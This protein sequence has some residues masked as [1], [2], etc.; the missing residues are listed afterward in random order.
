MVVEA[1]GDGIYAMFI[2]VPYQGQKVNTQ[3]FIHLKQIIVVAVRR[4]L[5]WRQISHQITTWKLKDPLWLFQLDDD[6]KSLHGKWL[7]NPFPSIEK[8]VGG[9]EKSRNHLV[10]SGQAPVKHVIQENHIKLQYSC[11][12][13]LKLVSKRINIQFIAIFGHEG[14]LLITPTK[15]SEDCARRG[16]FFSKSVRYCLNFNVFR[17]VTQVINLINL[18]CTYL[19]GGCNSPSYIAISNMILPERAP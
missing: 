6:S 1:Q 16:Q 15:A 13:Y 5:C 4:S 19:C 18:H 10:K 8:S 9:L 2:W 12:C 17:K 7:L 14:K 3:Y 11:M